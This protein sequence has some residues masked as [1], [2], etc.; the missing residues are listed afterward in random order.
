MLN[1]VKVSQDMAKAALASPLRNC[2]VGSVREQ[3][4][5]FDKFCGHNKC[6][7]CPINKESYACALGWAQMTYEKEGE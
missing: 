4:L 5:R 2:D 6:V 7:E 1:E 3:D